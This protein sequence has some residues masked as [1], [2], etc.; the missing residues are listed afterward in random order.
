MYTEKELICLP[1]LTIGIP[2]SHNEAA[3]IMHLQRNGIG[4]ISVRL[5]D[6]R[7]EGATLILSSHIQLEPNKQVE[8]PDPFAQCEQEDRM[9]HLKEFW[10]DYMEEQK[11]QLGLD[12]PLTVEQIER[13]LE[14]IEQGKIKFASEDCWSDEA[15][16][17]CEKFERGLFDDVSVFDDWEGEEEDD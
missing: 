6:L 17:Y 4:N 3:C 13:S 10:N 1:K 2:V 16:E 15:K 5:E 11:H 9:K 8:Q 12:N 7:V 14:L